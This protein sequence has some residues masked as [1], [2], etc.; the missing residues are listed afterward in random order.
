MP[1]TSE[2]TIFVQ[3]ASYRDPELQ[4]TLQDLFQK[5][6]RPENIFVGICHQY[7]MKEGTDSHLFKVPFP[8]PK[9]L[10]ID[11]VDYRDAQGLFFARRKTQLLWRSEKWTVQFDSHM[12]FE[13][14][15]DEIAVLMLKKLQNKGYAK[16]IIGSYPPG[17]NPDTNELEKPHITLLKIASFDKSSGI[18]R[19]SA[20]NHFAFKH[21]SPTAFVSGNFFF[22][23]GSHCE[24]IPYDTHMYFTDEEN[25]A[26]R[27]W[28]AG[29][30]LFNLD[31]NVC[32][33][34]WNN[35]SLKDSKAKRTL[36][37][38]DNKKHFHG[39]EKSNARERHLFNMKKSN[40]SEVL[41]NLAKY[42][43]GSKRRLQDYEK[44]SGIDFRKKQQ[45]EHTKQGVFEE[46]LEVTKPNL[47]KKIFTNF[48]ET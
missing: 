2:D 23:V 38:D 29:Y 43:L 13:D 26:V 20:C 21:C 46:W 31:Q 40:N 35:E 44:F 17:Y 39:D 48:A 9:Q 37:S 12:R 4:H 25:V 32:Y 14:R 16:P 6:K 30:N 10:R 11:E 42:S 24:E 8:R 3:I 28:T 36:I 15:W 27:S 33:H 5:A 7:D 41:Q 1:Y 34:L 47:I 19:I 22:T 45:R 18:I